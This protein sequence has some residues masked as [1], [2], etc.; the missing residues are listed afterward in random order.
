MMRPLIL[1]I[2]VL[3]VVA[4]LGAGAGFYAG[5]SKADRLAEEL[6]RTEAANTEHFAVLENLLTTISSDTTFLE[7]ALTAANEKSAAQEAEAKRLAEELASQSTQ[8][9]SLS[10]SAD[11][12]TLIKTWNPFVYHMK[13]ALSFDDGKKGESGGSAVLIKTSTG[14]RFITNEHVVSEQNVTPDECVLSRYDSTETYTVPG[15]LI[16]RDTERDF[17]EGNVPGALFGALSSQICSH[18]PEI[19][20]RVVMLG[21]PAIGGQESITATEG[22]ISGFDEQ[23]YTTSAKI[24]KGNSGG[25]AIDVEGNCLLGLPTLVFA[26][27][28]ESIA[29]I[30]PVKPF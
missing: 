12:T 20:D 18:I 24:E 11:I 9:S 28:I 3:V 2:T 6:A 15:A 16:T 17:A 8:L 29:R 7:D 23:Y 1:P 26:G 19:G 10:A 13:C 21:Y 27:R 4:A 30:L 5:S 22:I 25:A 14:V